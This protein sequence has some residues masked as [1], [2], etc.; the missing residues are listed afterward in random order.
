MKVFEFH[1]NPPK[2]RAGDK[3]DL[4]FD[5][6]CYEPENIY[7][8]KMGSLYMAGILKN[9]LP[10]NVRFLENLARII[11]EK[12]YK[13]TLSPEK[14]LR[15]TLRGANEFL[16]KIAKGGE[17]SWLGNLSFA[18][19]S[20]V[21]NQKNGGGEL[22]FTKVGESKILLIRKGQI[23][24]IE[25]KLKF[26]EIEPYPLKIFGNIVSGKLAENDL[27]LVLTK[28]VSDLFQNQNIL[29]Q[30]A[31]LSFSNGVEP[32][33]LKSIF[34]AKKDSLSEISGLCLMIVLSR[35]L[36]IKGKESFFVKERVREFSL[37]QVFNPLIEKSLKIIQKTKKS[38]KIPKISLKLK[39]PSKL[40][41]SSKLTIPKIKIKPPKPKIAKPKIKI[42]SFTFKKNL[43]L[44][45]LLLF[46]LA[47]GFFIFEKREEE[48]L[49]SYQAALNQIQEK[50]NRAD[51]F[52]MLTE[53]NPQAENNAGLLLNECWGEISPLV[54]LAP[55]LPPDFRQDI[56]SLE[57]KIS[58]NLYRLNKLVVIS[59]P[60]IIFEFSNR[61]FIP[62]KMILLENEIYFF[63]PYSENLFK[64]DFSNENAGGK[65]I[66]NPQKIDSAATLDNSLLF[67]SKPD[68]L[69]L[70]KDGEINRLQSLEI[71]G[72]E[73]NL[74][75]L[76]SYNFNLYLRDNKN[77]A[78]IKYAYLKN[79]QWGSP[80]LWS[81]N[82]PEAK[83]MA[84]DGSVWL[85]T[86]EN[87]VERY[88]IG[89]LGEIL[90]F[91]LFPSPKNFSKI[92]TS[93]A[94]PYLYISEPVQS[95]IIVLDK[96][97][98]IIKQFQSQKF[99]N[100]LD[101]SVSKDGKT[102]YLLNGLTV[103]RVKI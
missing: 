59:E 53:T 25:E 95:R 79:F 19:L 45:L 32:K 56:L 9:T 52:L 62:Q 72:Q 46:F 74:N 30:I 13:L 31:E 58:E 34:D 82:L 4:I 77:R 86:K 55:S 36:L 11:K 8:R 80:Q 71:S 6:F 2:K 64:A 16:E 98:K 1:F 7:E 49:R 40:K 78:I 41:I 37:K 65:L 99:N 85:L 102:I 93:P 39:L 5:S 87:S 23:I 63:S 90:D 51:T 48:K 67:F 17:V 89:K 33:K 69:A 66:E 29:K 100:L 84:V 76:S 70:F 14:S 26:E 97:G 57:K 91:N 103:Y 68:Q 12:Y 83:S 43:I 38:L 94:L 81:K 10:Q 60:E 44:I 22:N 61:E 27:I 15:E 42:K 47:S 54:V 21:L 35:E 24:D 96:S 3:D 101:F 50:A 18:V 73:F 75:N 20:L 92:F 28:E 88:Y